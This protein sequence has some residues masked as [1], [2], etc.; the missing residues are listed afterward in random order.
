MTFVK[1]CAILWG[2][3]KN[4]D[5]SC[6]IAIRLSTDDRDRLQRESDRLGM[7]LSQYV[8]LLL[9]SRISLITHAPTG[10]CLD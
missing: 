3:L 4:K 2:M 5:L 7:K 6:A 9:A 8:R 10:I 1:L